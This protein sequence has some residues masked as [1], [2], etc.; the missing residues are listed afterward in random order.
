[1]KRLDRH[2]RA[3]CAELSGLEIAV[4]R[5]Y[6]RGLSRQQIA[7]HVGLSPRTVGQYLTVAKEKLGANSLAHAALLALHGTAGARD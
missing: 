6:A 2:H 3:C 4:L 1:M 5:D 7:S